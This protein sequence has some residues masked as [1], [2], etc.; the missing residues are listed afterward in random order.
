MTPNAPRRGRGPA[1]VRIDGGRHAAPVA[2]TRRCGTCR[3]CPTRT[4]MTMPFGGSPRGAARSRAAAPRHRRSPDRPG[5]RAGLQ[6]RGEITAEIGYWVA[7]WARR[8]S[9]ATAPPVPSPHAFASGVEQVYLRNDRRTRQ[10]AVALACGFSRRDAARR[11]C[12]SGPRK[13]RPAGLGPR[14][15][16]PDGPTGDPARP[17]G[18]ELT[19]GVVTIRPIRPADVAGHAGG[20]VAAEVVATSVPPGVPTGPGSTVLRPCRGGWRR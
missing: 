6:P 14:G 1:P 19:D 2:A 7:P 12:Q 3:T 20:P 11:R 10:P 18:G 15:R 13:A 16:R 17:A 4:P 8:R 9:V 5:A